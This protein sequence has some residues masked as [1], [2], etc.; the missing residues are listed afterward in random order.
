VI[1]NYINK[2]F[3]IAEIGQAHEG[4]LGIAHS[5]IEE[6]A[7]CGADAIKFQTHIAEAESSVY[8]KFRVEIPYNQDENRYSYWKRMEFTLEQWQGLK[9]H[10]NDLGLVFISSPF[11]IEA[12]D[13]LEKINCQIY[14]IGSGEVGNQLLLNKILQTG[15]PV[16]LSS[17]MSSFNE[18]E[19][20]I[21]LFSNRLT[22]LV[23]FQCTTSYPCPLEKI[24]INLIKEFKNEFN[25][26]VGFSDH[27]GSIFPSL[28]AYICGARFFE[29]HVTFSKKMFG[30]D[31]TSSLDF[32]E[33]KYLIKGLRENEVLLNNS[34]DKNNISKDLNFL[35]TLFD[36]SVF[37]NRD[38][39]IGE[40]IE[41]ED[42]T[43]KKPGGLDFAYKDLDSIVGRSTKKN[44]KKND[45]LTKN[46]LK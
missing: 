33:F 26:P 8:D 19:L 12:V 30:Y 11:S 43:F 23:V 46:D 36:R 13:L 40:I 15:K 1:N 39:A 14:K 28:A 24:G 27:S 9:K 18:I 2:A 17:G 20:V 32:K 16:F 35:K 7:A 45:L 42:L 6:V 5:M 4:S 25:I 29:T 37:V 38:I 21:N 31:A 41:L 22:Q 10:A 34:V 3:I 44:L